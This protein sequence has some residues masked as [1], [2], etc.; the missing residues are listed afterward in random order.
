MGR[1]ERCQEKQEDEISQAIKWKWARGGANCAEIRGGGLQA[2]Q[3]EGEQSAIQWTKKTGNKSGKIIINTVKYHFEAIFSRVMAD[4]CT[5]NTLCCPLRVQWHC[6]VLLW[7]PPAQAT[8]K[9]QQSV[10]ALGKQPETFLPHGLSSR[11]TPKSD[12][13]PFFLGSMTDHLT[14][15]N[16]GKRHIVSFAAGRSISSSL[17]GAH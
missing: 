15:P 2:W 14:Q 3:M 7:W 9:G 11:L 1:G 8:A 10:F 13:N 4:G 12:R 6:S 17:A 5:V 16:S